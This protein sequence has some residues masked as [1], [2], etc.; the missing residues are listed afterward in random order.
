[1]LNCT[2]TGRYSHATM[3]VINFNGE[4]E[5]L[6]P[7]GGAGENSGTPRSPYTRHTVAV[8]DEVASSNASPAKSAREGTDH[9][10]VREPRLVHAASERRV[11]RHLRADRPLRR[12]AHRHDRACD[13]PHLPSQAEP[14]HETH[15]CRLG[16]GRQ[17]TPAAGTH[18][19]IQS[20]AETGTHSA[21]APGVPLLG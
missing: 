1:M 6:L 4:Y 15:S 12:Q 7:A 11:L 5:Q 20:R 17:F 10:R 8:W 21:T 16:R 18:L 2:V 9:D 3:R 19:R 14:A 13:A